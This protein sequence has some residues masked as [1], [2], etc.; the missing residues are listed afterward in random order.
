[1]SPF[2]LFYHQP[3]VLSYSL[4]SFFP[5]PYT[6]AFLLWQFIIYIH[7]SMMRLWKSSGTVLYFSFCSTSILNVFLATFF[8]LTFFFFLITP[9][10]F[11]SN[12]SSLSSWS[13]LWIILNFLKLSPFFHPF[14]PPKVPHSILHNC[15]FPNTFPLIIDYTWTQ[16]LLSSIFPSSSFSF[17]HPSI[18]TLPF[19]SKWWSMNVLLKI[20]QPKVYLK[21]WIKQTYY[22]IWWKF[23]LWFEQC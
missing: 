21:Y 13:D 5:Y 8:A 4:N 2:A 22:K 3:T 23:F 9:S 19:D 7:L 15:F 12:H 10:I 16:S 17:S 11:S 18:W 6:A 20:T 14:I 1:M